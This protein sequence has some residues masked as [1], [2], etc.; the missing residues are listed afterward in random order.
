MLWINNPEML[1]ALRNERIQQA[2]DGRRASRPRL[3]LVALEAE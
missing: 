3:K 2:V 1:Q